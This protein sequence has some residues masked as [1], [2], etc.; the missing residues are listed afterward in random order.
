MESW[1]WSQ[2]FFDSLLS[3]S[4]NIEVIWLS[5]DQEEKSVQ[6]KF[7]RSPIIYQESQNLCPIGIVAV[8]EL[9]LWLPHILHICIGQIST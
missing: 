7:I 1:S 5:I 8:E 3:F 2:R 9:Q 6:I 4:R